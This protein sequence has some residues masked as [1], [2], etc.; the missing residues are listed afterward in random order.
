MALT[1]MYTDRNPQE[2]EVDFPY[3]AQDSKCAY[4]KSKGVVGAITYASIT[5]NSPD[6]LKAAI[7]KG[8]VSVAIEADK[9]VF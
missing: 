7:A 9:T 6:L 8:P 4:D 1:F 5:Q 3:V 2:T